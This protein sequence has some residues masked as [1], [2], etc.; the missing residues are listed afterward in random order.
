MELGDQTPSYKT[1]LEKIFVT[2]IH[3]KFLASIEP[4]S[5]IEFSV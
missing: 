5:N 1:L 2:H 3:K 4:S